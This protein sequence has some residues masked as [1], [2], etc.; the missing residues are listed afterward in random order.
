MIRNWKQHDL[1]MDFSKMNYGIGQPSDIDMFFIGA[2]KT[3]VLGEIK[4]ERGT[5]NNY[6]RELLM[7]IA[8]NYKYD[9]IIIFITHDK[10]VEDGDKIVDISTCQV[11]EIYSNK[12]H[13]WRNPKYTTYVGDVIKY[14]TNKDINI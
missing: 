4:N 13:K 9:A 7:T 5:F 3:L 11:K 8:D 14:Y 12:E 6:Q 2:N 10:R 1:Y